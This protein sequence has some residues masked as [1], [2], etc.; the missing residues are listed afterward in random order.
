MKRSVPDPDQQMML[1]DMLVK[2][3]KIEP[4][5]RAGESWQHKC[6]WHIYQKNGWW[7]KVLFEY[8]VRGKLWF[9]WEP[10][11]VWSEDLGW[12]EW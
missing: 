10:R 5:T 12:R 9:S 6:Y 7:D 8:D 3:M 1:L 2:R 11:L 4:D